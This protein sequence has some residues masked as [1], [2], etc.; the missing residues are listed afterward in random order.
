MINPFQ[1]TLRFATRIGA[2]MQATVF[3]CFLSCSESPTDT[4][5]IAG[6]EKAGLDDPSLSAALKIDQLLEAHLS[7]EQLKP[8]PTIRDEVF[9]RRVYLGIIGRI[10]SIAESN[11]FLKSG[12]SDKHSSLINELLKND[13]GYTAHHF[14]FW[15]DIL[16]LR[17]NVH[18]SHEYKAWIRE[19]I[20]INT[21][22]DDL[23]RKLVS[24]HG[25]VFDNPAAAYYIR[26]T[27]MDLDNM[28]NTARIFL[29]T[30]M[31][32]AQCHDHPFDKWTQM[33]FFKMAAF[34]YGFDHRGG[35]ANRSA[36]HTAL[37]QEEDAAYQ[38]AVGIEKFP[39]LKNEEALDEYLAKSKIMKVIEKMGLTKAQFRKRALRGIRARTVV[40]QQNE[41]TYGS[42]GKLFNITTY[43]EVRHLNDTQLRLP[44]DYQYEDGEPH[45]PVSPAT[46]F[47]GSVTLT[48]DPMERK[49]AYANWLTGP[50]N[51]RFTRVIVNRLWKRT[52]GH[53][54]FEP[55]DNLTDRT[56]ISQPELLDFLENL[57]RELDY[58]IRAFQ[59][60]LFN[61]ELF[62]R[63]VHG[64]DHP[65]GKPYPFTGPLMTRMSAEQIWDSI[66]SLVLPDIDAHDPSQAKDLQR[67]ARM[68]A[69]YH[70]LNERPL[71]EVLPRMKQVGALRRI[72]QDEQNDYEKRITV[73]YD[74]G[75]SAKAKELT[76][77][78]KD[79]LREM[80][81]RGR[82]I[83]LVDL[84]D[85]QAM[86]PETSMMMGNSIPAKAE[87]SVSRALKAKPRKAP[88]GL[89]KNERNRW[90]KRER[91]N[92]QEFR[93]TA[94]QMARAV[95]LTSP[96]PRGHFLR[97]FGQS[98]REM[99]ENAI[100]DASVP[101]ALYLLNSSLS[102]AIHNPNSVLGRQLEGASSPREKFDLVYRSMLTRNSTEGESA[103]ILTDYENYQD[104]TIEDLVWALLNSPEF[105]FI[106]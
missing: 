62:R 49:K 87:A 6:V 67:L 88:E 33:D 73:A 63:E 103:R 11:R 47:G 77:E 22:Y 97:A 8:N 14:Q 90:E 93:Q 58:D 24:G 52:F 92:L 1:L 3:S 29:G 30:R 7:K 21:H 80:E 36:V 37:R 55:V 41:S 40:E 104:E 68:R 5:P 71:E 95:T 31:E 86:S 57:M 83:V 66:A 65:L 18:W 23:V 16:R 12:D 20:R 48:S 26:D 9:V 69:I 106:Q 76:E 94:K 81:Q 54:I 102:V 32:C 35:N 2:L 84:K 64:E 89:D 72:F 101:Q 78:L 27:G 91:D 4:D 44:H 105:L 79:K 59:K 100:L 17:V 61:T 99:I 50:E 10:P 43:L 60:V 85:G 53:G 19:Q 96:A 38:Q 56:A 13:A 75:N 42:I 25:L 82:E 98:D 15:A 34:T 70:S 28:S 45:D 46:L 51:P 39:N 74:S